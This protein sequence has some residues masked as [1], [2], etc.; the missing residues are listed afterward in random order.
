MKNNKLKIL[1]LLLP[2][3]SLSSCRYGLKE[4]YINQNFNST[5]FKEN[6]YKV[7]D[8]SLLRIDSRR[9]YNVTNNDKVFTTYNDFV[10]LG[11]D[12]S[13]ASLNYVEDMEYDGDGSLYNVGYGPTKKMSLIN[14]SFKKGYISK[15]FDGQMF[16]NGSYQLARVQIDNEGFG[17]LFQKEL[18]TSNVNGNDAYFALNFKASCDYTREDISIEPHASELDLKV[19]FYLKNS[20]NN[21]D[22]IDTIYHISDI[23]TNPRESKN[24]PTETSLGTYIFYGFKINFDI[25]RLQGI[26]ITY[27][28]LSDP[29]VNAHPDLDYSLMLYEMMIPYTSWL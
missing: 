23:P 14:P 1:L 17:K 20:V 5:V 2:V 9:T 3:L 25:T 8:N 6:Y 15:L 10:S 19:S 24:N 26:S 7:W 28:N 12:S 27:D 13:A 11:I 4:V 21:Y 22:V 16:C 29:Y 18:Q